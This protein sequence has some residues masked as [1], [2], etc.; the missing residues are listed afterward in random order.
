M[1]QNIFEV[2]RVLDWNKRT[3]S[4]TEKQ[5]N[6]YKVA[7]AKMKEFKAMLKDK[8]KEWNVT[9]EDKKERLKCEQMMSK[10]GFNMLRAYSESDYD[11]LTTFRTW[12]N[13]DCRLIYDK[14]MERIETLDSYGPNLIYGYQKLHRILTVSSRDIYQMIYWEIEADGSI[15]MVVYEQIEDT[16]EETDCV[17]MRLPIGGCLF[18]PM[19][20]DPTKTKTTLFLEADLCGYIPGYVQKQALK[21]TAYSLAFV[22]KTMKEYV[23]NHTKLMEEN[24]VIE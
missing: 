10:N 3:E 17:R 5:K 2:E 4:F 15:Y 1:P 7:W 8:S 16:P 22:R 13:T 19:P 24:P 12:G 6:K 11:P 18:E 14:N 20:N 9:I 23:K 21:D